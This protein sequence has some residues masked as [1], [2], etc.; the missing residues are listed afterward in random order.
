MLPIL[1]RIDPDSDRLDLLVELV[2]CL[3]P[4]HRWVWQDADDPVEA[5][6]TLIELLKANPSLAWALRR[7]LTTLLESRRHT[8]LYSDIG[9]LSND[10]F[11]TELKRRVSYRFL[12]PALND[13]Y[14][15]DAL[16][17]VLY[18]EDDQVWIRMVP[19]ADWMTLFDVISDAPPPPGR[20]GEPATSDRARYVTLMGLLDAI[21]T[22]SCRIC[23]LG[24]EPRLVHSYSEIEEFDSPFLMQNIEVNRYLDE[25]GRYLDGKIE[26][27]E[28]ARHLLVMLD[29][30]AGVVAKIRRSALNSG[31]SV[32]LTYLLVALQQSIDRLHK[33]LY[34]VDLSGELPSAPT[35]DLDALASSVG[36]P[37]GTLN[38]DRRL[39]AIALAEELIEAH[40]AKYRI[41]DLLRDNVDLLARNVTEN[42]SRTGEHYVAETRR[43]LRHMFLA[44]SGAGFIVAFMAMFKIMLGYLHTAPLVEAFLFSMNY[45]LGFILIYVLHFTVATKQPAMT[46]QHIAASLQ[47]ADNGRGLDVDSLAALVAKVFRSQMVAVLGNVVLAFPVAWAIAVGYKTINGD[48]MVDAAKAH[49]LLADIDPIHG[50]A[51]FYAAIAGV[52][53]FVSGLISGYYDNKALY[54]R[55]A[56][57]VRQLR[58]L[59]RLL[60]AERLERF[61]VYVEHNLGGLMGNFFFGLMLGM[62]GFVGFLL[63]LPLDIRHVAFS[64]ANFATALVGLDHALSWQQIANAG[65]GVALIG[66]VNLL[67]SF[68]LALWVAMRARKI[69]FKRG[70]LLVQALCRRF[71]TAPVE[72]FLGPKDLGPSSELIV[73]D[74]K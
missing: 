40:N 22:L 2:D 23:A 52:W 43:D 33:L 51:L 15:S 36:T 59:R 56:Q 46:A 12:P 53:L 68:G 26:Q 6:R 70:I 19:N 74:T 54:T 45:S 31:T 58:S 38:S 69:R 65:A 11:V 34:L 55:M 3:R 30:C 27:P 8:S 29:Q 49:H 64:T 71:F 25:Y 60:G 62:T 42:A 21:R 72:F 61:S 13:L 41:R 18:D 67:V 39:A 57:R 5:V 48:H 1:Q 28:D 50:A 4:R 32:A 44:A 37:A 9:V 17:Q 24:L 35:V 7:Y 10:G 66:A 63:G 20:S 16:D 47:K 14:L 73:R